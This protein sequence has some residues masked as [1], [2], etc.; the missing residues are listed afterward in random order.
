M[1]RDLRIQ[2]GAFVEV[3]T[4]ILSNEATSQLGAACTSFVGRLLAY[5]FGNETDDVVLQVVLLQ[6]LT[7]FAERSRSQQCR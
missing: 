2:Q 7:P 4:H 3:A 1:G 6:V 5:E